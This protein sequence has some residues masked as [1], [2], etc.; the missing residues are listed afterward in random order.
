MI[1][2]GG[3]QAN[4]RLVQRFIAPAVDKIKLRATPSGHG[5]GIELA[6]MVGA[7]LVL[8]GLLLWSSAIAAGLHQ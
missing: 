6:E 2:D 4:R 7:E 8:D 3:F 5:R 1:A